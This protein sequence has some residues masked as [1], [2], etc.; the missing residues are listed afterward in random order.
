M[1]YDLP[2]VN[3]VKDVLGDNVCLYLDFGHGGKDCGCTF[4]DGTYEKD[5]VLRFGMAV[6]ELVK[7]YFTK[8]HLTR[9]DDVYVGLSDRS[10]AMKKLAEKYSVVEAYSFHCNAFNKSVSGAEILLSIREPEDGSEYEFCEK[11]LDDYCRMFDIKNRGVKQKKSSKGRDLYYMHRTT[12]T[13]VNLKYLELFFGDNRHDCKK[14]QSDA[15]FNKAVFMVASYILK[16]Y[17]KTI[18]KPKAVS[19]YLYKVQCGAFSEKA[20]A[21]NLM[22]E[23]MSKGYRPFISRVQV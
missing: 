14:G 22:K 12:P 5:Y 9:D 8:V 6:Y 16:R 18:R 20:N 10:K 3:S 17:G 19:K 1:W 15:Y 11:F 13:N 21:D 4:Y 7:P 23:L 2:N